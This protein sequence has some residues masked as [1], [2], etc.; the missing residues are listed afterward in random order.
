MEI[1]NVTTNALQEAVCHMGEGGRIIMM[2]SASS[3]FTPV[4]GL[5][6][7]ALT[8]GAIASFTHGLARDL[9]TRG[10]TVNNIQPG[11]IDTD[12]NPAAATLRTVFGGGLE[13]SYPPHRVQVQLKHGAPMDSLNRIL[14][15]LLTTAG[16]L[17]N[18]SASF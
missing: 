7:Y 6:V 12:M 10:I 17:A 4:A 18:R 13:K 1:S 15:G 3:D 11:P 8:K 16:H 2:G 14:A 9:G 5:S